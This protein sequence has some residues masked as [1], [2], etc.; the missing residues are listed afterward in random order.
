MCT[1][2]VHT[3]VH[4]VW[5]RQLWAEGGQGLLSFPDHQTVFGLDTVPLTTPPSERDPLEDITPDG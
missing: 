3:R 5:P 1:F 2:I 4:E